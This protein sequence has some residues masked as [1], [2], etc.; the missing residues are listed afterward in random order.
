MKDKDRIE[1]MKVYYDRHA[2]CH[3]ACMSYSDNQHMEN[4]LS[5]IVEIVVPYVSDRTVLEIACGTG[6]WTEVLAKR[7]SSVLAVDS[8][9]AVL[10]I[11]G[12]KLEHLKNITLKEAD[13]YVLDGITGPFDMA[14]AADWWSHMP[15]SSIRLFLE[16][17]HK[18]L[19]TGS[20]IIFLDM[21]MRE[22][23]ENEIVYYDTDGNRVSLRTLPDGSEFEVIKNFP[24]KKDLLT[25]LK[26]SGEDIYYL[27]FEPLK[28]WMLTYRP[29]NL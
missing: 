1:A 23:F 16:N 5:P 19:G 12:K 27:E 6:N 14:F 2:P 10:D 28:R 8:S 24:S 26:G 17:L 18:R 13:A 25:I 22:V 21:M 20:R 11:A 3:D 7:A 4:L 29:C 9:P 15:K